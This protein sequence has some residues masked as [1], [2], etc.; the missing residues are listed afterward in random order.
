MLRLP[1]ATDSRHDACVAIT[2]DDLAA[3]ITTDW[4][5]GLPTIDAG[6]VTIRELRMSD[7]PSLL[8][9]L[10][11]PDVAR[12]ISPPPKDVAGF[13]RFISWQGH[14]RSTGTYFCFAIVPAGCEHAA[15]LVQVRAL[16]PKFRTAE[17][18][19]ALGT[20]FWGTGMFMAA[21]SAVLDFVFTVVGIQRVEARACVE[22]GRGN[23]ALE[24]LGAVKEGLLR[25]AFEGCEGVHDQFL[26]AITAAD[27][28]LRKSVWST[29]TIH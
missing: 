21:A 19:F 14:Q 11:T 15:G 20:P 8:A 2:L 17:W 16:D 25:Q 5:S 29:Q 6:S 13:E 23:R 26:W 10:T 27:R 28:I 12:F 1:N 9:N 3:V 18:G 24:K 22:N 7:A 4:K